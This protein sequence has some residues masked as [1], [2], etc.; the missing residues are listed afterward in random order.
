MSLAEKNIRVNTVHPAGVA[1]P[2][3]VNDVIVQFAAENPGFAHAMEN[4]MPVPIVE[5]SDITEAM[6]Y[7]CGNSGR[8]V[9]GVS[10]PVDAGFTIK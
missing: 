7:L 2:M 8:Y 10:L 3:I 4:L 1:T 5:A 9:T 6:V